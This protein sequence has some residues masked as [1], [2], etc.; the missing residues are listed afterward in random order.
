[1]SRRTAEIEFTDSH[2]RLIQA[3]A[4]AFMEEGYR[5]SIDRIAERAGVA[6]QT[7]YNHFPCKE[8]LFSEVAR[9]H[10]DTILVALDGDVGDFRKQLLDF[11]T[12]LQ[13]RVLSDE[14]LAMF[15]TLSAEVPHFPALGQAFF[16]KGPGQT[17]R[18][19]AAFLDR[20]MGDGH[21]RRDDPL[22]A[23]ETLMG[24]LYG[25]EHTRR[26]FCGSGSACPALDAKQTKIAQIVDCF[27][28][29]FA[30]ETKQP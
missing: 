11:A 14:G 5:A 4:E 24:M 7:V 18:G 2:Q 15:R 12:A 6:R 21:L 29:A 3:A 16:D 1:M 23:A 22:F 13:Q 30:R 10:A 20:A 19:L 8:D 25:Y 9:N 27:L 28:R 17:V 26:L